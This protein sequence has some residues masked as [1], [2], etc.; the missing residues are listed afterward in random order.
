MES[1]YPIPELAFQS[2]FFNFIENI[3][4]VGEGREEIVGNSL[5]RCCKD[6]GCNL[7]DNWLKF[8]E[9]D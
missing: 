4:K 2:F 7:Y 5:C 1:S 6:G 3:P 8:N 9:R